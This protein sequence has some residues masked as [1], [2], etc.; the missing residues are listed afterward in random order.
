M[1]KRGLKPLV[2]LFTKMEIKKVGAVQE[3]SGDPLK[4]LGATIGAHFEELLCSCGAIFL[5]PK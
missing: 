2:T 5:T 1:V 3:G 4:A